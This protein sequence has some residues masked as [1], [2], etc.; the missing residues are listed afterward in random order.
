MTRSF[1]VLGVGAQRVRGRQS[2]LTFA[3]VLPRGLRLHL[4]RTDVALLTD[5][6]W[7]VVGFA[8]SAF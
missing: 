2:T 5:R 1:C 3:A 4:K 6:T 7:L 8:L